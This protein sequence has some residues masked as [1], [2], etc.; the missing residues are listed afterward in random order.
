MVAGTPLKVTIVVPRRCLPRISTFWPTRPELGLTWLITG[1]LR[2]WPLCPWWCA[3]CAV[4]PGDTPV[5]VVAPDPV[6]KVVG[7]S[8]GKVVDVVGDD[9]PS[10]SVRGAFTRGAGT[11]GAL[12]GPATIWAAAILKSASAL[13]ESFSSTGV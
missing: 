3:W 8:P 11:N 2:L 13:P 5:V 12:A 4:D 9:E 10:P 6:A 7:V 1:G